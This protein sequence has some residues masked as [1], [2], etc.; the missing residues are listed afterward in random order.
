LAISPELIFPR[1]SRRQR[2]LG[3]ADSVNL[4]LPPLVL[5]GRWL[6]FLKIYALLTI[7]GGL[8]ISVVLIGI[9]DHSK[10]V[11]LTLVIA[12]LLTLLLSKLLDPKRIVIEEATMKEFIQR[13][14]ALNY[15]V[16]IANEG[17]NRQEMETVINHIIADM[18]G[19]EIEGVTSDKK[20]GNDLGID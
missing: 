1:A 3:F 10:W 6:T 20:L 11:L 2:Y 4:K 17:T 13:T 5:T 8:A 7:I 19:L 18:A 12:I 15:A 9:F 14:L 16:V